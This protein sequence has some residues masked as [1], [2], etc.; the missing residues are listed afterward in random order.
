[1][2]SRRQGLGRSPLGAH[3]TPPSFQLERRPPGRA[4]HGH[5]HRQ[6][7]G[8]ARGAGR[9][10][11]SVWL[12]VLEDNA[13]SEHPSHA[14]RSPGSAFSRASWQPQEVAGE[15]EGLREEGPAPSGSKAH[16]DDCRGAPESQNELKEGVLNSRGAWQTAAGQLRELAPVRGGQK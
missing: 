5:E 8:R 12:P 15:T 10:P 2:F 13:S 16:R 9:G 14:S 7:P 1:M 11:S 3:R 4:H 6:A